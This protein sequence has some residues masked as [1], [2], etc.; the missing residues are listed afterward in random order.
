VADYV[1]IKEIKLLDEERTMIDIEVS[2]N[3]LFYANN[4]LT[5]NSSSDPEMTDIS[6]C[7][8]ANEKVELLNGEV[9]SIK[10]VVPG[11]QLIS[12]D[13]YRTVVM[14]HEIKPKEC[15]KITLKSGKTLIVSKDHVFPSRDGRKSV[16]TGLVA[17]G[18]LNSN[19]DYK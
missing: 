11:D 13:G 10:D 7:I 15:V 17:G 19:E 6:E 16:N 3:H 18:F 5:H 2:G 4:I 9:K 8:Y 12:H 1:T 14:T